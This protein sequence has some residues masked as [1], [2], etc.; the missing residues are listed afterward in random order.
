VSGEVSAGT[1]HPTSE[2]LQ[3][4][5]D[6][7]QREVEGIT[8]VRSVAWATTLPMGHSNL[9]HV[10]FQV[11]GAETPPADAG[12]VAD[13][14][15]VSNSYF[16][17]VDVPIVAGRPFTS[18]DTATSPLVAIVSEAFARRY[19]PGRNPIGAQITF[20]TRGATRRHEIVGVAR[21]VKERPDEPGAFV[22]LYVPSTQTTAPETRLLVRAAQGDALRLVPAIRAAIARVDPLLPLNH[23]ATLEEVASD[24][25]ARPRFRTALV[26]AFAMLALTLAMVGVSGVLAYSVR[27]RRREFGVRLA[28]G[29]TARHIRALVWSDAARVLGTGVAIGLIAALLLG[30]SLS[31]FLFGVAPRD[32]LTLAAVIMVIALTAAGAAFLPAW[33]A[34]R[35][36]PAIVFRDV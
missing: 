22:Q 18:I 32:P 33:R 27:Q 11:V 34:S 16:G 15:I 30:Q 10:S 17:T 12:P 31:A 36:D 19:L 20:A 25:T 8:G 26:A 1:R 29:A 24:A 2:S 13:L 14:Q 4:F 6:A 21:Q 9:G 3:Q 35:T 28:L 7:V 5:F 23:I